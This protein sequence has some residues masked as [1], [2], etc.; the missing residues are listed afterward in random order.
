MVQSAFDALD[1]YAAQQVETLLRTVVVDIYHTADAGLNDQFRTLDARGVGYVEGRAV[2]VVC[3]LCHL[4]YGVGLGM[5]HIRLGFA[6]LVLAY[7]Q[8]F[9]SSFSQTD[10]GYDAP[11]AS[12]R[13][14]K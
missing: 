5:E 12:K 6:A 8:F 9:I 4:G 3:A 2:A 10:F 14:R 13:C 1:A 7:I 11:L